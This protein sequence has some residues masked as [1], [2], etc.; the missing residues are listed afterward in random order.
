MAYRN[1]MITHPAKLSAKRSQLVIQTDRENTVPMEDIISLLIENQQTTITAAALNQLAE[2]GAVIFVCDEHHLPGSVFLP[3]NRH[4]RRLSVLQNQLKMSKPMQKQ[5]WQQIIQQKIKN[6]SLCLQFAGLEH[7]HLDRLVK[8]VRSGDSTN[9]EATAAMLYFITLFG[10]DFIR[11]DDQLINSAL[12]YGYSIIRGLIAR[13]LAVY[14]F[15]PSLGI[16]HHSA[17]NNFNLADDLIEPF[18]PLVDLYV[19]LRL[20]ALPADTPLDSLH[21]Q[22]LYQLVNYAILSNGEI[23]AVHYAIERMIKSL[24]SCAVDGGGKLLLPELL[25]LEPH[26]YE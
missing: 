10:R 25:P 17:L 8:E 13:Y 9:A 15:E 26:S 4:S 22:G 7:E 23:H 6:Q 18:R 19:A 11:R 16:H 24:V 3:T 12:N 1:L 5:L 20:K 14:G 2:H 21:K